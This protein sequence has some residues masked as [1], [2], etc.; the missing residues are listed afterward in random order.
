ML[1]LLANAKLFFVGATLLALLC[2]ALLLKGFVPGTAS[3]MEKT[4]LCMSALIIPGLAF[5]FYLPAGGAFGA[6]D[7]HAVLG[8]LNALQQAPG[9]AERREAFATLLHSLEQQTDSLAPDPALLELQAGV[10]AS[11]GRYDAALDS[12]KI[13]LNKRPDD[14]ALLAVIAETEYLRGMA[15]DT[16]AGASPKF[17]NAAVPWLERALAQDPMQPRALGL[18]GIRAYSEGRWQAALDAWRRAAAVYPVGSSERRVVEQGIAAARQKLGQSAEPG[19]VL[20]LSLQIGEQVDTAALAANTPVFV[21]ARKV[22]AGG[23]PLAA[24]RL[25]LAD[26]PKSLLL[27]EH[28]VMARQGLEPGMQVEVVAR[29]SLSGQPVASA[30]DFESAAQQLTVAASKAEAAQLTLLIDRQVPE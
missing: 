17:A 29:L 22:N 5:M 6:L 1:E 4:L 23:P 2:S 13:L 15:S 3:R 16:E 11:S 8:K 24:K 27:T 25:V 7:Q 14:A 28:D 30:G 10:L 26:L 20:S 18:A 19:A 9:D 21:F 12:Y